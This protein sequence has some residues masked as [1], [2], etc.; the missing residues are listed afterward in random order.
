MTAGRT[1]GRYQLHAELAAG[2]M[3][4]VHLG[5]LLGPVGFARTVAIK[6]LHPQF[7]KD[8]EFVSM[9][10]DEA[11]LAARIRHPNVVSTL[12]VVAEEG[13]LFLVMDYVQ[14]ESLSRIQKTLAKRG[15]R[16]P[17]KM[18]AAMLVSTLHGLHAAH[19]AHDDHGSPLNVVHRDVSPQNILVGVDGVARVLDFGVAKAAGRVAQTRDGQIKGKIAYMAPEQ[20]RPGEIG[21]AVDVYAAG[22]VLWETLA[23]KRLV[24]GDSEAAMIE[25]VLYGTFENVTDYAP[26]LPRAIDDVLK[27]ALSRDPQARY[28]T[29]REMAAAVE[30]VLGVASMHEL[31]EWVST[32]AHE[33]LDRRARAVSAIEAATS[34]P[35]LEDAALRRPARDETTVTSATL[36]TAHD[37]P[38]SHER[39]L[40]TDRLEGSRRRGIVLAMGGLTAVVGLVLALTRN[41][42]SAR[43]SSGGEGNTGAAVATTNTTATPTTTTSITASSSVLVGVPSTPT[44]KPSHAPTSKPLKPTKSTTTKPT[45]PAPSEKPPTTSTG[46]APLPAER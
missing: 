30:G 7:A 20:F 28:A 17:P 45:V 11:R 4:T 19:E 2:G 21:R 22:V 24:V 41:S 37:A 38:L 43:T 25:R 1:I 18:T 26:E 5:R 39:A 12:D 16:I 13:E 46:P 27:K 8:P 10:V 40:D 36:T 23:H 29:A 31:S 15:E 3:A 35:R 14:G 42:G 34:A 32:V 44:S 33:T 6:R 9:F